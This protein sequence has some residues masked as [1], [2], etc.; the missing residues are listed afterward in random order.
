MLPAHMTGLSSKVE[1]YIGSGQ[2][3]MQIDLANV[4]A[5]KLHLG[6]IEICRVGAATRKKIV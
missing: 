2:Q 4:A 6:I 3:G 1:D 5:Y